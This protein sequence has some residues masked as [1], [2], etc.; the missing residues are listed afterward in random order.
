LIDGRAEDA[1]AVP[2]ALVL[3]AITHRFGAVR[4]LDGASLIVRRGT[5]HALLGENGAGKST[6]M[7]VAFGMLQPQAGAM[8]RDG[9]QVRFASPAAAMVAGI[10]MVHQHFTLVPAMTVAENVALGGAGRRYDPAGAAARV[11]A[12]A[13]RAG[14]ALDPMAHVRDLPV[15][16]QQRCEIVK[17]LAR[18]VSLLILDEPTAVL[19]PAEATELLRWVRG[20]ADQ[21]HAVVLITHKLRDALAVADD[22]TVLRK[23]RTVLT[24]RAA[25]ADEGLLARAMIGSGGTDTPRVDTPFLDSPLLAIPLVDQPFVDTPPNDGRSK[26][27]GSNHGMSTNGGSNGGESTYGGSRH[28]PVVLRLQDAH[29]RDARGVHRVADATLVVHAGEIVGIA[30]VEGS[31][32]HELL[33][34]LAGRLAP[35]TGTLE[36]PTDIGFVPEDRHRDALMLDASLTENLAL[37][38]AGAR[39]GLIPWEALRTTTAGLL[40]TFDV[41]AP[42]PFALARSLSGGNQQK[43]IFARELAGTGASG[44]AALIVE[45]PSRGL[46]F[47]ATAAVHAA[48][49]EAKGRGAAVVVYSSD[50]DEVLQLADRV[51]VMHAGRVEEVMGGRDAVGRAMV[52]E[53]VPLVESPLVENPQLESPQLESPQLESG[54]SNPGHSNTGF[55][56]HADASNGRSTHADSLPAASALTYSR[57]PRPVRV[58]RSLLP[59]IGL[60][61]VAIGL[62]SVLLLLTG[63][64]VVPALQ[65]L[66]RGAAGSWYAVTSATIPRMVPL[67][68]AGLAVSLAFRAGILNVGAEGQ[69]LVGAALATALT[70]PLTGVSPVVALPILLVAGAVGGALWAG[71]AAALRLRFGVLEVISTIMLNFVALSLTGWLVRGPLQEPTRVNPQSASLSPQLHLPVLL[72]GTRLHAGVPLT[73]AVA[74]LAWWWLTQSASGFRLRAVGAN[75]HAARSA[76]RIR[77]GRTLGGAFLL[78]GALAGLAGSV[79]YTGITYALYENFSPGYGYTAIAVALLARLHPVGVLVSALLFGALEAGANAM[80]RDAQVP[81]V[82]V[83]V[84]EAVLILLVVAADRWRDR[85][86]TV[87]GGT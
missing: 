51:L 38:D 2:P 66:G 45:N 29:Y 3:D 68:L 64:A 15:G 65:A 25:E 40:T 21:G 53:R 70:G 44:P 52:G 7:R 27:G 5:V 26:D 74:V 85:A 60:V 19:A 87:E 11:Q 8:Q 35:E 58:L 67:A 80:Q 54:H 46:D 17:A 81:S 10:G 28:G 20:Y 75:P 73:L 1:S 82:V 36:R 32:Q 18:D 61:A 62:M 55:S 76:G 31:G 6:L 24:T 57:T 50:L 72:D 42:G 33:R 4:A 34:L 63:H 48:L 86:K 83:S 49:R 37:R 84:V 47:L 71:I 43:F 16:A 39:R 69:L 23:G 13:E 14:L 9:A 12:V 77:T 56:N 78:S 41:R 30:A 79:E 22:L 59:L